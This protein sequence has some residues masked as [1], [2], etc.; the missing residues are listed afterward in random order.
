M[1]KPTLMSEYRRAERM[2]Q[3]AV[4][5]E[6]ALARVQALCERWD[7]YS[8]GESPTTASIRAALREAG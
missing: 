2:L 3:R 6:A 7:R 1:T 4:K 8:K 5:A